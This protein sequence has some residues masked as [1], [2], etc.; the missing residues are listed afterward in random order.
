MSSENIPK[1]HRGEAAAPDSGS[2][3]SKLS[4]KS[5]YITFVDR[6]A[7]HSAKL[8]PASEFTE[9]ELDCMA[10]VR[11]LTSDE[12]GTYLTKTES[13]ALVEKLEDHGYTPEEREKRTAYSSQR[14]TVPCYKTFAVTP[15]DIATSAPI[16]L[17]FTYYDAM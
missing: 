2:W 16:G 10:T 12:H 3:T 7:N 1:R 13:L 15:D 11:I 6:E 17:C 9:A 4:G 8:I 14:S 5:V